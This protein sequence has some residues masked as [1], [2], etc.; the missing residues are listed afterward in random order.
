MG[1]TT[2]ESF[3]R[4]PELYR[5]P[6][7][8]PA[9]IYNLGHVLVARTETGRL[10]VPISNRCYLAVLDQKEWLFVERMGSHTIEAAWLDF[11]PQERTGLTDPVACQRVF[12]VKKSPR[13]MQ[14]LQI[15]FFNVIQSIAAKDR[16]QGKAQVIAWTHTAALP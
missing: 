9:E 1:M 16:V 6:Y 4:P 5:E 15:E 2:R 13:Y 7:R 12:Y 8:L 14:R 3:R 11:Q 10:Y